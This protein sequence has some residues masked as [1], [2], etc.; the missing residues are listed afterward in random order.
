MAARQDHEVVRVPH[1]RDAAFGQ[2]PVQQVD[3]LLKEGYT[4]V[5][6]AD[7]QSYL[8]AVS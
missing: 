6:D 8:D 3:R 1:H 4:H 7:L 5:V 2:Q